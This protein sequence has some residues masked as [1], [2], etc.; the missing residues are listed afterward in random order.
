MSLYLNDLSPISLASQELN[1]YSNI[2][3]KA[4]SYFKLGSTKHTDIVIKFPYLRTSFKKSG[5]LVGH[6]IS[7]LQHGCPSTFFNSY[8]YC[9]WY[10]H[11]DIDTI[12]KDSWI[13]KLALFLESWECSSIVFSAI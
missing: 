3:S 4:Y 10:F 8:C 7:T 9:T 12:F 1:D 2:E 5:K 13:D 6:I 11:R